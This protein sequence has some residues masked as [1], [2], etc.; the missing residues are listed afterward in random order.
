LQPSGFRSAPGGVQ[1]VDRGLGDFAD[2]A[3]LLAEFSEFVEAIG[4]V[5]AAPD[6]QAFPA[7]TG[8]LAVGLGAVLGFDVE[9]VVA[10]AAPVPAAIDSLMAGL[11]F[12]ARDEFEDR[13]G[14]VAGHGGHD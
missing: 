12:F 5:I 2:P 10:P 1:G 8:V 13:P 6:A 4:G 11:T 9:V 7:G 3:D 14:V